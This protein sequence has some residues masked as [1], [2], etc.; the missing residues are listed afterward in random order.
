[1]YFY[2]HFKEEMLNQEVPYSTSAEVMGQTS[3]YFTIV[4]NAWDKLAPISL[5]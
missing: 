1:M 5:L 2:S 3:S 4:D